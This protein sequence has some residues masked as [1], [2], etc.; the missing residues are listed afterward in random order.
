MVDTTI[1]VE[2]KLID[3]MSGGLRA[4]QHEMARLEKTTFD[5]TKG[6]KSELDALKKKADE[7]KSSFGAATSSALKWAAGITAGVVSIRAFTGMLSNSISE[8]VAAREAQADLAATLKST[9]FAAGVTQEELN[10]MANSLQA[11]TNFEDDAITKSQAMLLTFTKIGKDIF[12]E[13]TE[14]TLNMAQKFKTDASQAAIQLGKA[15]NDPIGGVTALRRVGVMLT[16]QQEAQIK[17]MVKAGDVAAAQRVILAELSTEFGGLAR[18]SADPL[19]QFQNQLSN[20]Q[21]D[22]GTALLPALDSAAKAIG[23]IIE[24]GNKTGE[25]QSA[26]MVIGDAADL[27]A[28]AIGGVVSILAKLNAM[29]VRSGG[30]GFGSVESATSLKNALQEVKK[31]EEGIARH[32]EKTKG[33]A[34]TSLAPEEMRE[35]L[36]SAR[37]EVERIAGTV[38]APSMFANLDKNIRALEIRI[39]KLQKPATAPGAGPNKV[40]GGSFS[41]L[42]EEQQKAIDEQA[43]LDSL[44]NENALKREVEYQAKQEKFREGMLE[45]VR[46]A[47]EMEAK[48]AREAS[49]ILAEARAGDDEMAVLAIKQ[50]A[51][52]D[53]Y[54]GNE[55]AIT[56]LKAAHQIQRDT[57]SA[58][59]AAKEKQ[60]EED[61]TAAKIAAGARFAN[62]M[63]GLMRMMGEENREAARAAAFVAQLSAIA[64]TAAGVM[65][66]YEQGGVL[67][68]FT[69]AA[70]AAE[71]V[72]QIAS[73]ESAMSKFASG[74]L[75]APGGMALV[76]E[77]GPEMV[78]LPRGARVYNNSETRGMMGG[79]GVTHNGDVILQVA[80]PPGSTPAQAEEYGRAAGRGYTDHLRALKRDIRNIDY[81]NIPDA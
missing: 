56:D 14:A 7:Q 22:L 6:I 15:L 44:A 24:E 12:P 32:R 10:K 78:E 33:F 64:S 39:E 68:F 54:A 26:F 80:I 11:V 66:A 65:K 48:E 47:H 51:E 8:A 75:S 29:E 18:A 79:G 74:T 38:V 20:V 43:K 59:M 30:T 70:I 9:G 17:T 5:S 37:S 77:R 50:Q 63:V 13:A 45:K 73:I 40:T 53:A 69:G 81:M 42:T 61:L 46:Q 55:Q 28:K 57:L 1:E 34:R 62:A 16:D 31:A 58:E 49:R 21:E 60:R 35:R 52:L 3:Q 4:I 36:S 19:K 72:V 76:G 71:G 41:A 25:L 2:A 67:G 23:K 27:A